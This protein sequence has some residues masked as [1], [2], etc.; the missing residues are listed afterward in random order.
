LALSK[1]NTWPA[2]VPNELNPGFFKRGSNLG[3][4]SLSATDRTFY[5]L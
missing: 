1:F 2:G 4:C 5:G 3:C